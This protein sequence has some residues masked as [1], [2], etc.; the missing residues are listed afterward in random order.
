MNTDLRGGKPATNRLNHDTAQI[1]FKI[2]YSK[3]FV[4][5]FVKENVGLINNDILGS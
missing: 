3:C 4:K 5:I 1:A 2:Y